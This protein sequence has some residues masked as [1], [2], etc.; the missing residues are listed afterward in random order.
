[1]FRR[2]LESGKS[3]VA[4]RLLYDSLVA[5]ARAPVFH[6]KFGVPD[7]IDGR[8]DLLTL[9]GFVLL[10]ALKSAG[11]PGAKLGTQLASVIFAGFDD[12]LRELGVSDIGMSRR[13]K[14]MAGAFY[15]RLEAY[16]SANSLTLLADA[17]GRN[18]YREEAGRRGEAE[19][20][21]HY[22]FFARD[23]LRDKADALLQG[24]A[25]FGPLPEF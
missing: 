17:I 11:P 22:I 18:V 5:R 25:D 8:F 9:H 16:G 3:A 10:D 19:A 13:I 21:A 12:A 20:L 24:T 4:A 6:L 14:A 7:T 23:A 2:F 1:M 15:G